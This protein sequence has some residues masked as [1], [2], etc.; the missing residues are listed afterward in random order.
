M[1]TLRDSLQTLWAHESVGHGLRIFVALAIVSFLCWHNHRLIDLPSFYLGIVASILGETDDYWW[2]RLKAVLFL[3]LCS[4]MTTLAVSCLFPYPWLFVVGMSVSV[5]GWTLLGSLGERYSAMSTSIVAI[6]IFSMLN[7]DQ[8]GGHLTPRV[9]ESLCLMLAGNL[10][11]GLLTVVWT[12]L[13]ANRPVRAKLA[14]LMR[15]LG[16]LLE[17]KAQDFEAESL[18]SK[19]RREFKLSKQNALVM[20]TL[21]HTY[22]AIISRF[23]RSNRLGIRSGLYFRFYALAQ[24][25]HERIHSFHVP[26]ES[27][28]TELFHS[29]VLFR[30]QRSLRLLGQAFF[31]LAQAIRLGHQLTYTINQEQLCG[32]LRSAIDFVVKKNTHPSSRLQRQI[33]AFE[34]LYTNLGVIDQRLRESHDSK[35]SFDPSKAEDTTEPS[36]SWRDMFLHIRGQ[37]SPQSIL[38]RFGLRLAVALAIGYLTIHQIHL[39]NGYW[40]LLTIAFVCRPN[41]GAT[42]LRVV[43]RMAGTLFGLMIS[44]IAIKL[45][46][47]AEMQLVFALLGALIFPVTRQ[48][49]YI[50]ATTAV[51]I[52]AIFCFNLI[53]NGLLVIWPRLF[54]TL[55]GCTIAAVATFV[56]Y[57]DWQGRRLNHVCAHLLQTCA[58]YLQLTV[59]TETVSESQLRDA[60]RDMHNAN[61]ALSAVLTN[62]I[63][64][65]GRYRRNI[66][67]G[68]H[69]LALNNTLIGYLMAIGRYRHLSSQPNPS[70]TA[71]AEYIYQS[72]SALARTIAE[73]Q[74]MSAVDPD[75]YRAIAA[76][77]DQE[78]APHTGGRVDVSASSTNTAVIYYEL[79]LVLRLCL[80]L[81]Q[82]S[83]TLVVTSLKSPAQTRIA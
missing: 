48:N 75:K 32:H 72:L 44:W 52:M 23:G 46:P 6:A 4:A 67:A 45:C 55:I 24:D 83:Q 25:A 78:M 5:L 70:L 20:D 57:P 73:F 14:Q 80:P 12:I 60:Q 41:F 17:L 61:A 42:R 15:E 81:E 31:N 56:I 22:T 65:P 8:R 36:D 47:L 59:K 10:G 34:I 13:F 68:F 77:L 9:T 50:I 16:L 71:A 35:I 62:M 30:S 39:A 63:H 18:Q 7:I 66:D 79:A 54:D 26:K 33:N 27:L 76:S 69:F 29:D 51:T 58:N 28:A 2:Q 43:E 11:Y 21:D 53:G 19:A 82:C 38:F 40:V 74:S 49:N 1:T 64:E 3:A 37:L